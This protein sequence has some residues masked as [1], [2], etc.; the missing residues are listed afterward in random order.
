MNHLINEVNKYANFQKQKER[1]EVYLYDQINSE[2][3]NPT[4]ARNTKQKERLRVNKQSM[5][6][7]LFRS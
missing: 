2:P 7:D 5:C 1:L 4:K 3:G 6:S